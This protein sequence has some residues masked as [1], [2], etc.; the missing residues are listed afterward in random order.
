MI[1]VSNRLSVT[2]DREPLRLQRSTAGG[3][4]SA[5]S[6]LLSQCHGTWL[7]WPGISSLSIS[8]QISANQMLLEHSKI[9]G[10]DIVAVHL[11]AEEVS[12]YYG[13]FCNE[14]L[15][16]LFHSF[17]TRVK[18]LQ[19]SYECYKRVSKKFVDEILKSLSA[20]T[21]LIWVH[22][23]HLFLV[24]QML[25]ERSERV[26]MKQIRIGFF[27]HIPF[28]PFDLFRLLPWG[29]E[30]L[31]GLVLGADVIGFHTQSYKDNFMS[32]VAHFMGSKVKTF[33]DSILLDQREILVYDSSLGISFNFFE[34]EALN[35][36]SSEKIFQG[37]FVLGVDRLDY[38]KGIF[39]KLSAFERFLE[40]NPDMVGKVSL[41]QI[42]VPSRENVEEYQLQ[43]NRIEELVGKINGRFSSLLLDW[44][45]ILY[46]HRNHTQQQLAILYRD[47]AVALVTPLADGMNLVAKEYVASQT[48]EPGV[49]VLSKFAGAAESMK[50]A[51]LVNP[52]C[53]EEIADAIQHGL[54]MPKKAK[55]DRM[56]HLRVREREN[57]IQAWIDGFFRTIAFLDRF[58][59][60]DV[61]LQADLFTGV[62]NFVIFLDF[63]GTISELT[64][65][66]KQAV[67][68][69]Q[70]KLLIQ[71]L[72]E[73][74]NV[75]VGVV[76][77]RSMSD[78][79]NRVGIPSIAYASDHVRLLFYI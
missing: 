8:D 57:D 58:S 17:V 25:R 29:K 38:T 41:I 63:D 1:I 42:A 78:L 70:I 12:S 47:A 16:P 75:F 9:L 77:G 46:F 69:P 68:D 19:D 37:L 59:T 18:Y 2:L 40:L 52:F 71:S 22:D 24:P 15:W 76:S 74:S 45:P 39:E 43:K 26:R 54:F 5:L 34:N 13:V 23:Y 73:L 20:D 11:T 27:L 7:G 31:E 21:T 50:E 66:P 30:I 33:A 36:I 32:C 3:L 67:I 62:E 64:S 35:A 4:V 51:L 28:P 55:N 60:L 56:L 72:Q 65:L 49:L 10:Y 61:I 48:A 6:A 14:T 53:I 79:K 44:V